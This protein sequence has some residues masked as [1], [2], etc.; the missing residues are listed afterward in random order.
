VT[1]EPVSLSAYI[2]GD[3]NVTQ[4]VQLNRPAVIRCPAGGFPE[5]HVSWWRN[6]HMFGLKNNLMARDYSLVFNSIQLTDLGLYTCEVYNQRRP[7]SLRV[8]L[9]AVGP[10]R[11]RNHEEAEYLQYVLDPATRPVTQRPVS[12]YRPTRPAYVPEPI[13]KYR[14]FACFG[15]PGMV[16][17]LLVKGY[18]LGSKKVTFFYL[19]NSEC[20]CRAGAG[21]EEQLLTGIH[22]IHEL[23]CAGLSITK[24]DLDQG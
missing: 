4:I 24:C 13:G 11:A 15:W 20:K 6:G 22:H 2:Y 19:I 17:D 18:V 12:P 8:T 5:P 10:V 23:L 14:T 7:V 3:K 16:F 1:V 9:K 21:P